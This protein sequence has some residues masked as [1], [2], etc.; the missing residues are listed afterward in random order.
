MSFKYCYVGARQ[1]SQAKPSQASQATAH[2]TDTKP[3]KTKGKIFNSASA[4][5]KEISAQQVLELEQEWERRRDRLFEA[6]KQHL[7]EANKLGIGKSPIQMG[8]TSVCAAC[9]HCICSVSSIHAAFSATF[10]LDAWSLQIC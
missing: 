4:P 8:A 2:H 1:G 3:S 5:I 7:V 10:S 9:K 6:F